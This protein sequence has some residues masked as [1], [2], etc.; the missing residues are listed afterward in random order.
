MKVWDLLK[1]GQPLVS[2]K[3]H[4]KTVTCLS[5]GSNG[6]RL[7]SASL[8]RYGDRCTY[9]MHGVRTVCTAS[10]GKSSCICYEPYLTYYFCLSFRHVKVYNTTNYKVVHNFDYAASILSLG[11]AVRNYIDHVFIVSFF[12]F[13]GELNIEKCIQKSE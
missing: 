2:M 8:D 5:L 10:K 3:N 13:E 6:Q 12:V 1:G 7:L 9:S 11:L 4:H